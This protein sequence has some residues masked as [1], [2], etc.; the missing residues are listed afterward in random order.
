MVL[1]TSSRKFGRGL[2]QDAIDE[3]DKRG[4]IL[5]H[6]NLID[7][8]KPCPPERHLPLLPHV[9]IYYSEKHLN[10]IT[11]EEHASLTPARQ[12]EYKLSEGYAGC[13][14]NCKLFAQCRG[15]LATKQH[16]NSPLLKSIDA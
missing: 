4:I 8:A 12:D 3:A 14:Q 16:S 15:R 11:K 2:V 6:W 9:P 10:A 13:L 5:R 7:S 1:M